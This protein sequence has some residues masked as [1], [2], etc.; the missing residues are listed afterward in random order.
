MI[1]FNNMKNIVLIDHEPFTKRRREIFYIE[2]LRQAG[3]HVE[4]WDISEYVFPGM[5][6]V[7][8][9]DAAYVNKINTY[10]DF[11]RCLNEVD[12]NHTIFIVECI[13]NWHTRKIYKLLSDKKCYTVKIDFYAN[14]VL[15]EPFQKKLK[16]LFSSAFA[17]IIKGKAKS[18]I[19]GCYNKWHHVRGFEHYLSSSAIVNRTGMINHPD[20]ERF[21]F[22]THTQLLDKDYIVFCDNYFPYHPD[23]KYFFNYKEMPDGKKYQAALNRFFDYLENKYQMPVVIAAHPKSDYTGEEFGNRQIIKY[24]TDN[25]IIHS[26]LVLL[27]S[28]NSIS[29]AVL[30][31]KPIAFITTDGYNSVTVFKERMNLLTNLLGKRIFN[32]DCDDYDLIDCSNIDKNIREKYI[33]TY[34]TSKQT[35][36]KRNLNVLYDL[37]L[38]C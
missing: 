10:N 23:F 8:S 16:R 29:Y 6:I 14:T 4:V 15:R 38:T 30:A 22:E 13:K 34:L 18:L 31:D 36:S 33:F 7:D 20:Y 17:R 12:I 24:Q 5:R 3:F 1:S 11:H 32:L 9:I 37:L 19:L 21:K 28:S 2:E 35:E 25:L 27:H 26:S